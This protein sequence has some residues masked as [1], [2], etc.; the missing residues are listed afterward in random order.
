LGWIDLVN[1][2]IESVKDNAQ[3]ALEV[4]PK[5][6]LVLPVA[7]SLLRRV[8]SYEQA[9]PAFETAIRLNPNPMYWV[10]I[11]YAGTLIALA[12]YKKAKE[13]LKTAL[14]REEAGTEK[15]IVFMYL[16][17]I[18]VFEDD[19]QEAKKQC[20][21]AKDITANFDLEQNLKAV[22][23]TSD[24]AFYASLTGAIREACS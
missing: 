22:S 24:T 12:E 13:L 1:G 18:S 14:N 11:E 6:N 16:A 21:L 2:D 5:N 9:R 19:I 7:A 17:A 4:A 20:S 10:W 23:T 15:T 3:L 8:G